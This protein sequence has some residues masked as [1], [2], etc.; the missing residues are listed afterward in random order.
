MWSHAAALWTNAVSRQSMTS[1]SD[2]PAWNP[3]SAESKNLHLNSYV[4]IALIYAHFEV[5]HQKRMMETPNI[6]LRWFLT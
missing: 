4:S 6:E 1:L 5:S 3:L 2:K